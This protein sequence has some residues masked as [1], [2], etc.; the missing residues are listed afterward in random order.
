MILAILT[1]VLNFTFA[2]KSETLPAHPVLLQEPSATV[3]PYPAAGMPVVMNTVVA[4][5]TS[6][7]SWL[8][9]SIT[10]KSQERIERLELRVFF[11]DGMGKLVS[12]EQG[13]SV[14]GINPG[15]TQEGRARIPRPIMHNGLSIVT[16]TKAV[17]Q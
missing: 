5:N 10:N 6:T 17:G 13:S 8:A 3:I 12:M 7:D 14:E 16:I 1:I 4:E 15:A 9:Y 11:V 2:A